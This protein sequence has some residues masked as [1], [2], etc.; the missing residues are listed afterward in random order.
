MDGDRDSS[1]AAKAARNIKGGINVDKARRRR[2]QHAVQ[3]RK[4]KREEGIQKRRLVNDDDVEEVGA[5]G[6]PAA[7]SVVT[8]PVTEENLPY[9]CDGECKPM[10]IIILYS[11]LMRS[12]D[13]YFAI[14]AHANSHAARLAPANLQPPNLIALHAN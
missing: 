11:V 4:E 14:C 7:A 8:V 5:N 3:I 2:E 6:A 10:R 12:T 9:F 13:I 1:R